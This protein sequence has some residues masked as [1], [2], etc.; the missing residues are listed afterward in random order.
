MIP[1]NVDRNVS[2]AEF[3][4]LGEHLMLAVTSIFYTV[5]GEGPHAGRPAVFLRL[6]GCNIGAKKD[7]PWCDTKFDIGSATR[8]HVRDVYAKVKSLAGGRTTLV[9]ITGG[10]PLLQWRALRDFMRYASWGDW[11]FQ[12]ETNGLYLRDV[13]F[14]QALELETA[15][16]FVVSPKIPRGKTE[17]PEIALLNRWPLMAWLKY[18]VTADPDSPYHKIPERSNWTR[19]TYISGMTVYKRPALEGEIPSFWGDMVDLEATGANYRY[20]AQLVAS[21]GDPY[22]LSYQTHILGALE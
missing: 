8:M 21:L 12:F 16:H 4:E 13:T 1:I 15:V 10:E 18:V 17:Y 20:A 2:P 7:C 19:T 3:R 11:T 22:R 14:Y 6:A 9:V 5:Q